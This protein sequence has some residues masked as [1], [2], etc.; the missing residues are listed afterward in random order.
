LSSESINQ[1]GF[2]SSLI[3]Q[4]IIQIYLKGDSGGPMV[5]EEDQTGKWELVGLVSTGGNCGDAKQAGIYT[6]TSH[7]V[8]WINKTI[9]DYYSH[10]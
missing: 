5:R 4:L 7:F 1:F 9:E 8:N 10:H 3:I 6:K 2:I